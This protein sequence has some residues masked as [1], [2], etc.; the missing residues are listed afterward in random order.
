[1]VPAEG[2]T[3][4]RTLEMDLL[5][6]CLVFLMSCLA[7]ASAGLIASMIVLER[8]PAAPAP[9]PPQPERPARRQ[10]PPRNTRKPRQTPKTATAR[11]RRRASRA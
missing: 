7:L 1:L 5:A 10:P 3:A 2:E 9:T 6:T 11:D 8:P 4:E